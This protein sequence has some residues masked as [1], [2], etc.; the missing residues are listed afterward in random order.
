MISLTLNCESTDQ[1]HSQLKK[2]LRGDFAFRTGE[3]LFETGS[4]GLPPIT[5][6][7]TEN[8]TA[9]PVDVKLE[10]PD[11]SPELPQPEQAAQPEKKTRTRKPKEQK[12]AEHNEAQAIEPF[13]TQ[14][15]E[16]TA[17]SGTP[18][19][20]APTKEMVH[21]ALQQVNVAVNLTKAREILAK[22]KVQ[23]I[24]ELQPPQFQAF[25]DECNAAVAMS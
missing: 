18:V 25:I 5:P 21:Q 20:T 1:L 16:T 9:M 24:S 10:T 15:Q 22:F 17:S 8:K 4:A 2:I 19:D 3:Q 11:I 6:V 13:E 12:P 14:A 7:K 23:R